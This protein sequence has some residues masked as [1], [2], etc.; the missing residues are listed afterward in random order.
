MRLVLAI[1]IFSVLFF[2]HSYG[3]EIK[4]ITLTPKLTPLDAIT[5]A[6]LS[7]LEKEEQFRV[8]FEEFRVVVFRGYY[9]YDVEY[10]LKN[11]SEE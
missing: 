7:G 5:I 8:E 10:I 6:D 11:W 3:Q 9:R 1:F 2:C 4:T